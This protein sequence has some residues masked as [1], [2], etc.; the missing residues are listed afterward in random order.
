M[1][2][3]KVIKNIAIIKKSTLAKNIVTKYSYTVFS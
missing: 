1:I 3:I 2:K